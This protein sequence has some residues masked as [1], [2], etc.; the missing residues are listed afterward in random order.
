LSPALE[1]IAM[2]FAALCIG[3]AALIAAPGALA[4]PDR[5]GEQIVKQQCSQCHEKGLHGAPRINDRAAWAQR[6]KNG[7]DATVRS[8]I[9]GHGKM[10]A[11]GGLADTTD[12][13]LRAAILYLFNPAGQPPRPASAAPPG[14]N[15]RIVDGTEVYLGVQRRADGWSH[16]NIT[17]R[18]AG[19]HQPIENAE[20]EVKVTNPVMGAETRKLDAS[21]AGGVTSYGS[22]FRISGREPH[23][24][25]VKVR[26]P[27]HARVI[28]TNFDYRESP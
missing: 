5:T 14:P 20:V 28:E 2:R 13:E 26:R 4:Q 8:A 23:V 27:Q 24:I 22:D 3:L 12:G 7:L 9:R 16:V 10:P 11:R 15:Q 21:K 25:S 18:D 6:M 19:T 1:E 17:L